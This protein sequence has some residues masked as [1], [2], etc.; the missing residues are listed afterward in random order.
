MTQTN[1]IRFVVYYG[2]RCGSFGKLLTNDI[3]VRDWQL[4]VVDIGST[5]TVSQLE[6]AIT[7]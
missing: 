1:C 7:I 4:S 3:V 2:S 6:I 5:I